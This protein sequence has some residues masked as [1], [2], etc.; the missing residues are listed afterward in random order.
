MVVSMRYN[1]EQ[2]KGIGL[3]HGNQCMRVNEYDSTEY[4]STNTKHLAPCNQYHAI[5]HQKEFPSFLL[6]RL[7]PPRDQLLSQ[8]QAVHLYHQL[9]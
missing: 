5:P 8:V 1:V 6:P 9:L 7:S 4:K 2:T 3:K